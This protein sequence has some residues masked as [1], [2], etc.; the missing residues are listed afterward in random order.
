[1]SE[2]RKPFIIEVEE[3]ADPG[4]A[5]LITDGE[6]PPE[7]EAMR[8]VQAVAMAKTSGLTKFALSVFAALF[9]LV[10]TV[11]AYDFVARLFTTNEFLGSIAFVLVILAVGILLY[12]AAREALGIARLARIDHLREEAIIAYEANDLKAAR[13]VTSALVAI[14]KGRPQAALGLS[15]FDLASR[16]IMDGDAQILLAESELLAP[17]DRLARAE[18]EAATRRVAAVTAI[19]P[20]ALADVAVALYSNLTMIRKIAEI[21][22]G[23]SGLIGSMT[24]LRKVFASLVAAGAVGIADD[25]IGSVAGGGLMSRL[26]RRFGEGVVNGAL[27]AR[28]GLAAMEMCRP[29][30]FRAVER[31]SV[32]GLVGA[33]IVG[34]VPR[35]KGAEPS[36]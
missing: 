13:A 17:L 18:V 22:G 26:S 33:A 10:L 5:P 23:R 15:R 3:G 32:T 6:I 28:V 20:M 1:M 7:G 16:D 29:L 19:V 27:T 30:P 31:P 2:P 9:T 34:L 25:M 21:Y 12:L 4:L 8:T 11:M 35:G 24:L 36:A 14:Y